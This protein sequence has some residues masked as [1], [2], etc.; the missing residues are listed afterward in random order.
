MVMWIW[1][2]NN[3]VWILVVSGLLVFLLLLFSDRVRNFISAIEP[4]KWHQKAFGGITFIF[5]AIEGIA[6]VI[7]VLAF[8]AITVS[9]EG[10]RAIITTQTIQT[11]FLEHGI[12]NIIVLIIGVI[13]WLVL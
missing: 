2:T 9:R 11:W 4:N 3:S 8:I 1:F 7:M 5:W 13:L 6:V 10:A 12:N